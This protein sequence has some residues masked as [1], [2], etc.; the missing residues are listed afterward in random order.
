MEQSTNWVVK[1]S[2]KEIKIKEKDIELIET[3]YSN[4]R[5]PLKE[6]GKK[7]GLSKVAV[8]NRIKNLEEK[9]IIMGYSCFIDFN[10]LGFNMYQIG[11]KTNM[12]LEQ[13]EK[14]VRKIQK[15]NFVN[16]IAKLSSGK[17]DFLIRIISDEEQFNEHLDALA[18]KDIER[19]EIL[20]LYKGY[21]TRG[22]NKE[23]GFIEKSEISFDKLDVDLLFELAKD[24]R[25]KIVDLAVK[26]KLSTKSVMNRIKELQKKKVILAFPTKFNPFIYG[27]E[28]HILLVTTKTRKIQEKLAIT[29]SKINSTGVFTNFQNP[30]IF[31][32]HVVSTLEDIKKIEKALKPFMGDIKNYEFVKL[33]E[34]S[35]YDFFPKGV[36][37]KLLEKE[38]D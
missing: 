38:L 28:G 9:E 12:T 30:N 1:P 11:I 8:F 24:S 33:E 3:I 32:F 31:S 17:W 2:E 36:Y 15:D 29:L 6:I 5:L 27:M 37:E 23:V 26:L 4:A 14:Y 19:M 21:F 25:Q 34:Q 13:K 10:K 16:Q 22:E 18:D 20:Q 35:L 7:L